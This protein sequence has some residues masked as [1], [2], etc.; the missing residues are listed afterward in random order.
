[1]IAH[2]LSTIKSA[3]NIVVMTRGRIVEQGTHEDL[4]E[5]KGAYHQLVEAQRISQA[6]E[7]NTAKDDELEEKTDDEK[8]ELKLTR[9]KSMPGQEVDPDDKDITNKLNRTATS[10]SK[11]SVALAN[12]PGEPE[13]NYSTWTL[14]KMTAKFNGPEKWIMAIGFFCSV[15][16][17]GGF[18]TQ[19]VFFAKAINSFGKPPSEYGQLRKD[20]DF[21]SGMYF[22]LAVVI[23]IGYMGQGLAFAWCSEKLV[24]RARDAAF[25]NLLRQDIEYFDREENSTGALTSFLSTETTHLAGMSG[26]TLGTILSVSITL[27]A[28]LIESVSIGWKLGLVCYATVPILLSCGT[29]HMLYAH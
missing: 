21:W 18:P 10:K 1:V 29:Y 8:L 5:R 4:L 24:H 3:D 22:M 7:Q 28:A 25:R 14:I 27:I 16:V 6:N 26:S 19:A 23:M 13:R 2:R 20:L 12:R 11:S 17:G 9:S 15:I